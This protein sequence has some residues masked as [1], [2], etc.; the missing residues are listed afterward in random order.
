[1][2]IE[3]HPRF[4]KHFKKR[5]ILNPKLTK[6]FRERVNI[7]VKDSNN[8]ILKD[9]QLS[10]TKKHLRAFSITG[11]YRVTYQRLSVNRVIFF[12]VGTHPQVY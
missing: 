2:V 3:T 5:I 12:D 6:R 11:N 9:H 10:G 4:D 7:F 1:M 8:P